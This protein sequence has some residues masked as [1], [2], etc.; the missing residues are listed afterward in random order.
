MLWALMLPLGLV[1]IDGKGRSCCQD[2]VIGRLVILTGDV[3]ICSGPDKVLRMTRGSC[4]YR[5]LDL[6]NGRGIDLLV[7]ICVTL[8]GSYSEY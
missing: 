4:A 3:H 5:F 1:P 7:A 2:S 6:K 8:W